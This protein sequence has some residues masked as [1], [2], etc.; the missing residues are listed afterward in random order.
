[1]QKNGGCCEH[2]LLRFLELSRSPVTINFHFFS[3]QLQHLTLFKMCRIMRLSRRAV[4]IMCTSMQ[5]IWI[6]FLLCI[7]GNGSDNEKVIT[8]ARSRWHEAI[9][10]NKIW[11]C[12]HHWVVLPLMVVYQGLCHLQNP[13]KT[14]R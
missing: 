12:V 13:T 7:V 5:G 9:C 8:Q 6:F 11:V 2:P 4:I 10:C 14:C 3:I 1:M